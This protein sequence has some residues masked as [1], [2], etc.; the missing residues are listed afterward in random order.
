MKQE[1]FNLTRLLLGVMIAVI[2]AGLVGGGVWYV[3][4]Q[5]SRA[6][7]AETD[8]Q[9]QE[10]E[11]QKSNPGVV[12]KEESV[13]KKTSIEY[14]NEFGKYSLILPLGYSVVEEFQGCE[15]LCAQSVE[16]I[17]NESTKNYN[18]YI[19]IGALKQVES[20]SLQEIMQESYKDANN[21]KDITI[22]GRPA[23][24]FEL[25]GMFGTT[26]YVFLNSGYSYSIKVEEVG[27]YKNS[28]ADQEKVVAEILKT[29]KLN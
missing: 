16:I 22:A 28:A 5:G 10:L 14:T 20:K 6:G 29:F 24:K 8:K 11:K 15:G 19:R 4:E 3:M 21:I 18:M 12:L 9:I 27:A 17:K 1:K 2:S 25:P 13:N 23:K 26:E 7:Q